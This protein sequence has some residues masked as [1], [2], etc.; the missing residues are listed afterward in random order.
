M[1]RHCSTVCLVGN[2]MNHGEGGGRGIW[3]VG[4]EGESFIDQGCVLLGN[5]PLGA[6]S[7][8]ARSSV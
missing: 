5:P 4:G 6:A 3:E 1:P 7:H 2:T 8:G